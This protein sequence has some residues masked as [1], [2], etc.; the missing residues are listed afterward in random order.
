[1]LTFDKAF[2]R[3][4]WH[5]LY[6]NDP[7]L[8]APESVVADAKLMH[9]DVIHWHVTGSSSRSNY[10]FYQ[11]KLHPT[12]PGMGSRDLLGEM[13]AE[14][15]KNNIYLVAY[16]NVHWAP[17]KFF[18]DHP[19]WTQVTSDG[20]S[21]EKLYSMGAPMCTNIAAYQE[22]WIRPIVEEVLN[23]Y[24]VDGIFLDGPARRMG[25]CYCNDC[26]R[27]FREAYGTD[28]PTEF[29]WSDPNFRNLI[30][31]NYESEV[32]FLSFVRDVAQAIRPGL[33]V[34]KNGTVLKAT[35]FNGV[36]PQD[37]AKVAPMV[38]A[39]AFMYYIRPLDVPSWK[40][41][42]VSKYLKSCARGKASV[43]YL[44]YGQKPWHISS[45]SR[46][47][48]HLN[49]AATAAN[50]CYPFTTIEDFSRRD[51]RRFS[52]VGE[53]YEFI[54]KHQ[55]AYAGTQPL[56]NVGV[57]YSQ[58]TSDFYERGEVAAAGGTHDYY[59]KSDRIYSEEFYGFYEALMHSGC[60]FDVICD[61]ALNEQDIER[62]DVIVLP[63][64]ACLNEE[65]VRALKKHV[66]AGKGLVASYH[67]SFYDAEGLPLQPPSLAAELG[68]GTVQGEMDLAEHDYMKVV[69]PHPVVGELQPEAEVALPLRN[70]VLSSAKGA[71]ALAFAM[72]IKPFG[73]APTGK[74]TEAATIITNE[75]GGRSV[76]FAGLIGSHYWTY[77][78]P[79]MQDLISQAVTW[80]APRVAARVTGSPN[81]EI[82][83]YGKGDR[84]FVHLINYTSRPQLPIQHIETVRDLRIDLDMQPGKPCRARSLWSGK[85]LPVDQADGGLRVSLDEMR[86][87]ELLCV[88]P[89]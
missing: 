1:M 11:S 34:Y 41:S 38:G 63:N 25:T 33:P 19:D 84:R 10:V 55:D 83:L 85:E 7:K 13:V 77:G 35:W 31:F 88:E 58:H 44:S 37:N 26:R 56:A 75:P 66:A 29:D 49:I 16:I 36:S 40:A 9:A 22:Q 5:P 21:V 64:T 86:I 67:A 53:M 70:L 15:H 50:G 43:T 87:Y 65:S 47:Q 82:T 8:W 79:D 23:A 68:I 4:L 14:C 80:A 30:R 54:E 74:M 18:E 62:F 27:L 71:Q 28:M 3:F 69:A 24:N 60:A 81:V 59:C 48:Q 73:Y 2:H 57:V 61:E 42:G 78:V 89:A 45:M 46:A 76:Y 52:A 32:S 39:E 20:E 72:E 17:D 12:F 51:R 6:D